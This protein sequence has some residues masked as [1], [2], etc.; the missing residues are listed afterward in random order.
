MPR[1]RKNERTRNLLSLVLSK[2]FQNKVIIGKKCPEIKPRNTI[3][4][5]NYILLDPQ[6]GIRYAGL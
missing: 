2:K 4:L 3:I 6:W 1:W 5:G